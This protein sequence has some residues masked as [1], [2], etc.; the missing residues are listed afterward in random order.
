RDAQVK[1]AE[2][3]GEVYIVVHQRQ[4]LASHAAGGI[5]RSDKRIELRAGVKQAGAG[6]AL[7]LRNPVRA[8]R[9]QDVHRHSRSQRHNRREMNSVRRVPDTRESKAVPLIVRRRSI[10]KLEIVGIEWSIREWNLIV[11]SIIESLRQRVRSSKLVLAREPLLK[12]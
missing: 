7:Q 12:T 5:H 2:A 10:L 3:V 4:W 8:A 11:V 1:R 6:V 9:D